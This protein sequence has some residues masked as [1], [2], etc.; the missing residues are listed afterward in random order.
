[1]L[2]I[3]VSEWRW[4]KS[5]VYFTF[6]KGCGFPLNEQTYLDSRVHMLRRICRDTLFMM[7]WQNVKNVQIL[8][9]PMSLKEQFLTI[10]GRKSGSCSSEYLGSWQLSKL[11]YWGACFFHAI[12]AFHLVLRLTALMSMTLGG[13]NWLPQWAAY[14]RLSFQCRVK[15]RDSRFAKR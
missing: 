12:I 13:G 3:L 11:V 5:S 1:M 2:L 8:W 15:Q 6:L 14:C 9:P 10:T 4:W 7:R